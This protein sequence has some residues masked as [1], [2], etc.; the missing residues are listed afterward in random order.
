MIISLLSHVP[1]VAPQHIEA[2]WYQLTILQVDKMQLSEMQ[3]GELDVLI[4]TEETSLEEITEPG[5]RL[6][7]ADKGCN[8][9]RTRTVE[10]N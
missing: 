9:Q 6:F 3:H 1:P 2:L 7:W 4:N 8:S 10:D 5:A